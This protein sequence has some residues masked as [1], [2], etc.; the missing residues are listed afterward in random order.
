MHL[1]IQRNIISASVSVFNWK[2]SRYTGH[3]PYLRNVLY[4]GTLYNDEV[5]HLFSSARNKTL[6]ETRAYIFCYY[7]YSFPSIYTILKHNT[8]QVCAYAFGHCSRLCARGFIR[9]LLCMSVPFQEGIYTKGGTFLAAA[10]F[11]RLHEKYILCTHRNIR[12]NLTSNRCVNKEI[13]NRVS[14]A[15]KL[16]LVWW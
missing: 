9:M 5:Q 10:I 14:F 13:L 11:Q 16:T 12:A 2:F 7:H 15:F 6:Y 1:L 8:P 3:K 4:T